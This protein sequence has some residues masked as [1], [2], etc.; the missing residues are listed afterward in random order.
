MAE[1]LS[2]EELFLLVWEKP[3]EEVARYL[4]ISG[5]ALANRCKKLHVPQP[6]A[7]YWAKIRAGKKPKKPLLK[8][9]SEVLIDRQKARAGKHRVNLE[10]S[11]ELIPD[12]AKI[13]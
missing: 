1:Q 12:G 3:A 7:G 6:P 9:F 11:V 10:K 5:A 2:R 13:A 8:E 4:D